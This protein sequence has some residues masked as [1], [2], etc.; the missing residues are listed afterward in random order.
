MSHE[1]SHID[2]L[3]DD[4]FKHQIQK[5][6]SRDTPLLDAWMDIQNKMWSE[7]STDVI[8]PITLI[9]I[10]MKKIHDEKIYFDS[11]MQNDSSEF[12]NH[13]LEFIHKELS[14][15]ITMSIEGEKKSKLDELYYNNLKKH[16]QHFKKNY[17][18]IIEQFY[19]SELSLT[20]CPNC[21]NTIDNHEPI[22]IIPVSLDNNNYKSL[23]D[24][25]DEYTSKSKLDDNNKFRCEKCN[26]DVNAEKKRVFWDV[27]PILIF[28]IKK[29][30]ESGVISNYINYPMELDMHKY[31]L[32]YK[33]KST[34]Y[35]LSGLC[36]HTGTLN[37]G[38]YYSIC[39]N[40]VENKWKVYNDSQVTDINEGEIF[41]NHPYCLFYK[42]I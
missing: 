9:Q 3:S 40:S 10:F 22:C 5:Y 35:S 39:K 24:C 36:I 16:E 29:Y 2:V 7:D 14:R 28:L 6:K 38:H 27:A 1:I 13:F 33:D 18:Y 32:N 8:N 30:N 21:N 23:Y 41:S 42:N 31:S 11:F 19:S 15:K 20:Q 25:I 26:N 37:S 4:N 34:K 12:L 17:S